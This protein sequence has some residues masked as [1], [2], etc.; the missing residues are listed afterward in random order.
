MHHRSGL[1]K[2][3]PTLYSTSTMTSTA[4]LY[5]QLSIRTPTRRFSTGALIAQSTDITILESI[6][7]LFSSH[8]AYN[9]PVRTYPRPHVLLPIPA[10]AVLLL[11]HPRVKL[12]VRVI[13]NNIRLLMSQIVENISIDMYAEGMTVSIVTV[14]ALHDW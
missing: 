2:T 5:A 1:R 4:S 10:Q 11:T 6:S 7:R 13:G 9:I 3:Q 12:M 8:T 14:E